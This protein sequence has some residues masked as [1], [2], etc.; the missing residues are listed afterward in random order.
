P[1]WVV[2]GLFFHGSQSAIA[3]I[4]TEAKRPERGPKWLTERM[5]KA[6]SWWGW[7]VGHYYTHVDDGELVAYLEANEKMFQGKEKWHLIRAVEQISS[8]NVRRLLRL[9][10]SRN[11]TPEDA[12]V[13]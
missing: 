7:T 9:L 12:V 4:V 3:R 11:S 6:V 5:R 2:S 10:A 13:R 8:E 1:D